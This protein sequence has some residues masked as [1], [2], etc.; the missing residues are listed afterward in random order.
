MSTS[1]GYLRPLYGPR[2][3]AVFASSLKAF[4]SGRANMAHASPRPL[5][6]RQQACQ[7]HRLYA[8][9]GM[10]VLPVVSQTGTEVTIQP[11]P[12]LLQREDA[13][14]VNA[15]SARTFCCMMFTDASQHPKSRQ[16]RL[17]KCSDIEI[18]R[19]QFPVCAFTKAALQWISGPRGLWLISVCGH[20]WR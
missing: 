1:S 16:Y 17:T 18:Y 11:S 7:K 2:C 9:R 19:A 10:H 3:I 4:G 5:F 6:D 13:V 15:A 20:R 8:T 12:T 14:F